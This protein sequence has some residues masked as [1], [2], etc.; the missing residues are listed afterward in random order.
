M[1]LSVRRPPVFL[2]LVALMRLARSSA[3]KV[4]TSIQTPCVA[5]TTSPAEGGGY[6]ELGL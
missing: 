2:G 1:V 5:V 6:T 3:G 4:N